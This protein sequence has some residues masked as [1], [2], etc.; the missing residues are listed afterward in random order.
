MLERKYTVTKTL[1]GAG[2]KYRK[3]NEW[4][5]GD[6]IV[7]KYISVAQDNYKKNSYRIEVEEAFFKDGSAEDYKGKILALNANGMVDKAMQELE[8]G[9]LVQLEYLGKGT[10]EKGPYAGKEAHQVSVKEVEL[11]SGVQLSDEDLL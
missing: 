6:I 1:S 7:G 10:I 5:I 3:W 9:A 4:A 2:M 11:A 8:T